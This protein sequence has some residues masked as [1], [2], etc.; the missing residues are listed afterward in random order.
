MGTQGLSHMLDVLVAEG[1]ECVV[2][3][4]SLSLL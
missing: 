1:A 2:P 4:L 3:S